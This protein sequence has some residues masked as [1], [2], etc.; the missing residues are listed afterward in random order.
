[1][2]A[3]NSQELPDVAPVH[4]HGRHF[5]AAVLMEFVAT[6]LAAKAI[7][8]ELLANVTEGQLQECF[9]NLKVK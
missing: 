9:P 7:Q 1:M 4:A 5:G 2:S 3:E 8:E 6:R